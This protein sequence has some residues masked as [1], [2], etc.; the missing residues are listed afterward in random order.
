MNE[1]FTY[2]HDLIFKKSVI[3]IP[4]ATNVKQNAEKKVEMNLLCFHLF[5]C[6]C[7]WLHSTLRSGL[8]S[9]NTTWW[10]AKGFYGMETATLDIFWSVGNMNTIV[11]NID[12]IYLQYKVLVHFYTICDFFP[13]NFDWFLVRCDVKRKVTFLSSKFCLIFW[14]LMHNL[15][16]IE[17]IFSWLEN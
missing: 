9:V 4:T 15:T 17:F 3:T 16:M 13:A 11:I 5:C 2:I 12:D 7:C 1:T 14:W 10:S 8:K 6:C